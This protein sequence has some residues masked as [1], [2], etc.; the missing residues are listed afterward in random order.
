M[1]TNLC[2]ISIFIIAQYVGL[3]ICDVKLCKISF[4][5]CMRDRDITVGFLSC[6]FLA[7]LSFL[8]TKK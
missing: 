7:C 5:Q 2:L 8:H 3:I 4:D 6:L 1:C